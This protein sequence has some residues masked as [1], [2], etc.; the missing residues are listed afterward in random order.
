MSRYNV[1]LESYRIFCAVAKCGNITKAA[2]ELFVTQPSVSMSI[3]SLEEKLGCSL[4]IR[5]PKGVKLTNEGKVFYTY[6]TQAIGLID[7]AE[8][9]YDEMVHL[10]SGEVNIGASDSIISGL[11]LPYLEK[12]NELYGEI[13][14]K[15]VN[16]TTNETIDLIRRGSIDFGFI[17]LP[18]AEDEYIEVLE[19]MPIHD[20]LIFGTK[21]KNLSHVDFNIKDIVNYPLLMLKRSSHTRLLLDDYAKQYGITISPSIELDSTDLLIKFS[22]INLGVAFVI[23]EFVKNEIDNKTLFIKELNPTCP[24]R[25]I[26]MVKLKNIPLSHAA[27]KFVDLILEEIEK[28]SIKE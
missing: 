23:E 22:K 27:S 24:H 25:A 17:N 6:L 5:F 8:Q 3:K 2:E 18:I 21:F 26:G 4:F 19:C 12:Y 14:I 1:S 11:L 16:R 9:K 10:M 13:C 15:V 28:V 20:C 7:I